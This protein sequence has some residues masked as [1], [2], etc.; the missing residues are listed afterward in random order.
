MLIGH[1]TTGP[2]SLSSSVKQ[3]QNLCILGPHLC[4]WIWVHTMIGLLKK[5][6]LIWQSGWQKISKSTSGNLLGPLGVQNSD[7]RAAG[8]HYKLGLHYV[9]EA[10]WIF[11]QCNNYIITGKEHYFSNVRLLPIK[12]T[13]IINS[14][15]LT[16]IKLWSCRRRLQIRE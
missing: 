10:G 16:Y 5:L 3:F 4:T 9:C 8:R 12:L 2:R 7:I 11:V 14:Q 15:G 13:S 1:R 6:L